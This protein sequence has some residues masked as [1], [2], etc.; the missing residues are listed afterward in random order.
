VRIDGGVSS[1]FISALL[2]MESLLDGPLSLEVLGRPVSGAYVDMTR[3]T[4]AEFEGGS[5]VYEVPG[6]DSAACFFLAGAALSSGTVR[7]QGLRRNS[8]QPDAVFRTW[9]EQAGAIV[10][11]QDGLLVTGP[12]EGGLRPLE[13]NVDEAPDAALPLAALLAFAEGPSRLEG[14]NRLKDKESDRLAAARDLLSRVATSTASD[15]KGSFLTIDGSR[16]RRTAAAFDAHDDHRVAM[17]AAVLALR[18]EA[19][20][21]LGGAECVSKSFP[22]FFEMWGSLIEPADPSGR[23]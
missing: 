4:L 23:A 16:S 11:W 15:E 1:Q 10:D 12:A 14:T 18:C 17:S 7:L 5:G 3:E 9:A 22:R 2:L 13:V 21:T 20:S 6:D 19:G 8:I